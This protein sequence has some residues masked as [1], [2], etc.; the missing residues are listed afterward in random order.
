MMSTNDFFRISYYGFLLLAVMVWLMRPK[1]GEGASA[2][3]G[4]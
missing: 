3:I 4:H 1:K 2:S